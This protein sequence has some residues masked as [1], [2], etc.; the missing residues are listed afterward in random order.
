MPVY[1]I[2]DDKGNTLLSH[3]ESL[4]PF[5]EPLI[6]N[7]AVAEN[8]NSKQ[9]KAKQVKEKPQTRGPMTRSKSRQF[10]ILSTI[11]H[12]DETAGANAEEADEEI[13]DESQ[14]GE[15]AN[16]ADEQSQ[17]ESEEDTDGE[18]AP[19]EDGEEFH[20][21]QDED[22][23]CYREPDAAASDGSSTPDE[24][25][26][27]AP[28]TPPD[29]FE[30]EVEVENLF[31][32]APT[33][34]ADESDLSGAQSGYRTAESSLRETTPKSALKELF[35]QVPVPQSVIAAAHASGSTF[36]DASIV[37]TPGR[38]DVF[39]PTLIIYSPSGESEGSML[40]RSGRKAPRNS[41]ATSFED[42]RESPIST[43]ATRRG[44]RERRPTNRWSDQ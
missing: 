16:D 42:D 39:S 30:E 12:V 40:N 27:G 17:T 7:D 31:L 44:S 6:P 10:A 20:D 3:R 24:R 9:P 23:E 8:H 19:S 2:K 32:Q 41:T 43:S 35:G 13:I 36:G 5:T 34:N 18:E 4:T 25:G 1:I 28:A 14:Q 29:E 11:N 26:P 15:N 22:E 38:D 33:A 37:T 21:T